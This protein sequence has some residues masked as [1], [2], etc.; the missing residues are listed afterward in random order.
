[1]P[2]EIFDRLAFNPKNAS[3]EARI[4][5]E[6][7]LYYAGEHGVKLRVIGF[8]YQIQPDG[9]VLKVGSEYFGDV[10]KM[11]Q[12]ELTGR[13]FS[14]IFSR[15]HQAPN[16]A[17]ALWISP[18]TETYREPR[19]Y[20]Y[21][22]EDMAGRRI[23]HFT[24]IRCN[25]SEQELANFLRSQL[26]DLPNTSIFPGETYVANPLLVDPLEG[27]SGKDRIFDKIKALYATIYGIPVDQVRGEIDRRGWEEVLEKYRDLS[28]RHSLGVTDAH[29]KGDT[30]RVVREVAK[31]EKA[32]EGYSGESYDYASSCGYAAIYY[33]GNPGVD[34]FGYPHMMFGQFFTHDIRNTE[35]GKKGTKC[36][37]CPEILT[38]DVKLGEIYPCCRTKR[39]C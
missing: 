20:L 6:N 16:R 38:K 8:D 9:S 33:G 5:R 7:L 4:N 10:R 24:D 29:E 1:M 2:V 28:D 23:V 30:L 14:D 17:A 25:Y 21:D 36:P 31:F 13:S 35:L 27:K 22:L 34:S 37:C 39:T 19:L 11:V 26:P 32:V 18:R 3:S 12:G 15:L